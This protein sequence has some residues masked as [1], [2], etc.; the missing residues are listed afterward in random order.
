MRDDG[1][2]WRIGRQCALGQQPPWFVAV[3]A[4]LLR[5]FSGLDRRDEPRRFGARRGMVPGMTA[6]VLVGGAGRV[7]DGRFLLLWPRCSTA[8][9]RVCRGRSTW[10]WFALPLGETALTDVAEPRGLCLH[11]ILL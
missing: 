1:S 7:G 10:Y 5:R 8:C 2:R 9:S 6:I 3:L 11:W 4:L